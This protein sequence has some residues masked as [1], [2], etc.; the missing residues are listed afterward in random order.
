MPIEQQEE[1]YILLFHAPQEVAGLMKLLYTLL[2]LVVLAS[3]ARADSVTTI[4]LLNRPA[5]EVIPIVEPMLGSN[6]AISGQG[7]NIFLRSSPATLARIRSIIEVLDI[8]ARVLQISVFQGSNRDLGTLGISGN[9]RIEGGDA[10]IDVGSKESDKV[11]AGGNITFSTDNSSG[12]ISGI[13]TQ[14]RLNDSPVHQVRVTE[15]NEAYM[16]TGEQIPYF[17]GGSRIGRRGGV[18]GVEFKDVMTG[19]YVLPRIHGDNVTLQVSPFRNAQTNASG[20]NIETQS[21]N[22][23]ITGR[24]G[25]WLLLGGATEQVERVQR[26]TGSYAATRSGSSTG[27]WIKAD[28]VE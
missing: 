12:S 16:E 8:P 19:F 11:D 15:G 2:G 4:Q 26:G 6:D 22:T 14:S 13:S 9:I 5:E 3:A 28:L 17:F 24:I 20:I 7:F 21:A 1:V 25:Q 23:T 27:I 10:S 18:G